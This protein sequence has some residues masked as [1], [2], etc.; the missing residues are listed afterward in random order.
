MSSGWF[1]T[2]IHHHFAWIETIQQRLIFIFCSFRKDIVLQVKQYSRCVNHTVKIFT[3]PLIHLLLTQTVSR[4]T[5]SQ[6]SIQQNNDFIIER[7]S[8]IGDFLLFKWS[9]LHWHYY[10]FCSAVWNEAIQAG[11]ITASLMVRNQ[12]IFEK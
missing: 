6:I 4:K 7:K 8:N 11:T 2:K 1:T 12:T 9:C 10:L 5:F 3:N